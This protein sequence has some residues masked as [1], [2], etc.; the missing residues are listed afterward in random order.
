[1]LEYTQ[2]IYQMNFSQ[3]YVHASWEM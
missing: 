3:F 2:A 1:M